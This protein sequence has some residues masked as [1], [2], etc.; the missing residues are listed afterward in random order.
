[1]QHKLPDNQQGTVKNTG[2]KSKDKAGRRAFD[3]LMITGVF[4]LNYRDRILNIIM[5]P[6]SRNVTVFEIITG[7]NPKT[8]PYTVQRSTPM[9]SIT[10]ITR[11]MSWVERVFHIFIT[12]GMNAAVVSD[13]AIIPSIS[14]P[15]IFM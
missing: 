3:Y 15:L 11:E 12:W 6:E 10:N 8:T 13:P 7:H 4:L 2:E 14:G 1:V 5:V 9:Q